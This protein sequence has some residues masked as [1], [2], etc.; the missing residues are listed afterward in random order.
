LRVRPLV[1]LFYASDIFSSINIHAKRLGK[2]GLRISR[3]PVVRNDFEM[4]RMYSVYY[5]ITVGYVA[6]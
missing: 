3:G 2:E 5:L 6:G 1:S 4:V